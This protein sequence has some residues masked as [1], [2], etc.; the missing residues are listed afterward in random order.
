[1]KAI[2]ITLKRSGFTNKQIN[3]WEVHYNTALE[4]KIPYPHYYALFKTVH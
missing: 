3:E 1:M 2:K 4:L